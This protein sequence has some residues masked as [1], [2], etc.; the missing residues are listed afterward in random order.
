MCLCVCVRA[1]VRAKSLTRHTSF[2][3]RRQ[4]DTE[5]LY[6]RQC[7]WERRGEGR[8][9]GGGGGGG[10]KGWFTRARMIKIILGRQ[11]NAFL[12]YTS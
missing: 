9:G 7:G 8:G 3:D 1:C 5:P 11:N 10:G 4:P 2:D 12:I 6:V